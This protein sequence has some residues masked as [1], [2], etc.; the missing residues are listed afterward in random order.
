MMRTLEQAEDL[1]MADCLVRAARLAQKEGM[2]KETFLRCSGVFWDSVG[3]V[4]GAM[5]T[6]NDKEGKR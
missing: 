2:D 1:D 6:T 5:S 3:A 4:F